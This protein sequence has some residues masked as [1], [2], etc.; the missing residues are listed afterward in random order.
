MKNTDPKQTNDDSSS[1]DYDHLNSEGMEALTLEELDEFMKR[2]KARATHFREADRSTLRD[3]APTAEEEAPLEIEPSQL[4]RLVENFFPELP[5]VPRPR[6]LVQGIIFDFDNTLA[7]LKRPIEELMREGAKTAEAYMRA[8]G[9]DDLP[10]E[11]WESIVEARIF[12][13]TK[14]DDEQEE[15]IAEDTLSFLLQ[16]FGYPAS[17]MDLD[18]LH[19]AVDLFYAPEMTAW[20]AMPDAVDL[21]RGLSEEGYKIAL[22][23]NYSCDRVFQ[24]IVDYTGLRPYLDTCLSSAAVE[25]R[26]PSRDIYDAILKRWDAEPYEVVCVGDSLKHDIAGGIDLGAQTIHCRM[27]P[28]AEDQRIV[29]TVHPDAVVEDLSEIPALIHAWS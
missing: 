3:S 14:S 19:R 21:L 20:E 24:R 1:A 13:Q 25:W 29:E 10:E 9:M 7:R 2:A 27:I 16:F 17:K 8:T 12:A 22:I 28:L 15:H 5:A 23:A 26:K 4:A 18:V 6:R 11:F